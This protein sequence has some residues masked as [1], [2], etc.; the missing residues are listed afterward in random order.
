MVLLLNFH[1]RDCFNSFFASSI[2][3]K[4]STSDFSIF[5]VARMILIMVSVPKNFIPLSLLLLIQL[6]PKSFS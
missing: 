2:L 1:D 5:L 3:F 4:F 6:M